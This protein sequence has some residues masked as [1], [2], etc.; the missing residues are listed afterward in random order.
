MTRKVE[1]LIDALSGQPFAAPVCWL[2]C[3]ENRPLQGTPPGGSGPHLMIFHLLAAA[4]TFIRER[5]RY[6]APEPL[7]IVAVNS[8]ETLR[9]LALTP[10]QDERYNA[11]PCGLVLDFDYAAGKARRVLTPQQT[12]PLDAA[13]LAQSLGL[14]SEP[15]REPPK[16]S[17]P[18][19]AQPRPGKW[20]K[21]AYAGGIL[22]A[23]CVCLSGLGL[24]GYTAYAYFKDRPP[25]TPLGIVDDGIVT[26]NISD[27]SFH[28]Y[29][30]PALRDDPP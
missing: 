20:K 19:A 29:P 5:R 16:P 8:A 21:I 10:A 28:K 15:R 13:G 22:L 24:G 6:Y 2:I 26:V 12:A 18:A 3:Y 1:D 14:P 11:P 25:L 30:F 7:N 23:L 9:E 17:T 27:Y 4:E